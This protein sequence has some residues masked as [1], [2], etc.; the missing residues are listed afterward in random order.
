M[1]PQLDQ[2][3]RGGFLVALQKGVHRLE[4]LYVEGIGCARAMLRLPGGRNLGWRR[5][6]LPTE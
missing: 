4:L 3:I 2:R 6:A 1:R 5:P